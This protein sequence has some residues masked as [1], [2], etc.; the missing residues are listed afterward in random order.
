[1]DFWRKHG[2]AA[3]PDDDAVVIHRDNLVLLD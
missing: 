1:M 3:A 2:A